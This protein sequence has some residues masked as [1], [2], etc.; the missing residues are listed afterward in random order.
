M[1]RRHLSLIAVAAL[2]IGASAFAF[3]SY[4]VAAAPDAPKADASANVADDTVVARVGDQTL[5]VKQIRTFLEA[6][7]PSAGRPPLEAVFPMVR[8]Q[9]VTGMIISQKAKVEGF[10]QLP[11]VQD[12]VAM[13]KENVVRTMYLERDINKHLTDDVLKGEYNKFIKD[14]KPDSEVRAQHI[15]V[16]DEATAKEIIAKIGTGAKFED[17]VQE[18]SKDKGAKSDGDLGFFKKGDMVKEFAD[19]AFSMKKGDVSKTPV[20]TQ[21]GYHVIKVNDTRQAKA[22][23]FDELKG[24]IKQALQQKSADDV[25]KS[26]REGVKVDVFGLDGQPEAKV[27]PAAAEKK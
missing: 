10:D 21:F 11:E 16:D 17:L 12:R 15:L 24:Q 19:V 22:P 25:I 6:L 5:T 3:Q 2:A 18:Y 23:S 7:P 9:L 20:K 26:Y 1:T 13:I 4:G 27:T 8:E 14:F